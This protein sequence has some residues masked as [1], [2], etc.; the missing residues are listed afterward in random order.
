MRER[1]EGLNGDLIINTTLGKGTEINAW[2][3]IKS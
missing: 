2:I 3:P 1:V